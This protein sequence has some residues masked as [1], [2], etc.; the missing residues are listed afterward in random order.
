MVVPEF[1]TSEPFE[2]IAYYFMV[3]GPRELVVLATL[4]T[5]A[6]ADLHILGTENFN[7]IGIGSMFWDL[8]FP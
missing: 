2:P 5:D 1:D 4:A 8:I 7:N 3:L 6:D